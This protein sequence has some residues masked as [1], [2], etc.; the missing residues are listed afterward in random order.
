MLRVDGHDRPREASFNEIVQHRCSD[1]ARPLRRADHRDRSG[2]EEALKISDAY[3]RSIV[4]SAV[5]CAAATLR[6]AADG[7]AD[8][9]LIPV[10]LV[11]LSMSALI[12]TIAE[13]PDIESAAISGDSVNG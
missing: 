7:L 3:R 10:S 8:G 5:L 1:A 2:P 13:L 9:D 6:P 4:R 12:A 11:R